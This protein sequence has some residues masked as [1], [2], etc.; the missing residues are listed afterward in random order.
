MALIMGKRDVFDDDDDE[1]DDNNNR[2]WW[3]GPVSD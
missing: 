1:F 2:S 3:Y